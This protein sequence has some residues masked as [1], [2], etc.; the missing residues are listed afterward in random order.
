METPGLPKACCTSQAFMYQLFTDGC[1]R[2]HQQLIGSHIRSI[3][4]A[5]VPLHQAKDVAPMLTYLLINSCEG[6]S[7]LKLLV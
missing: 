7:V 3:T 6:L 5:N 1:R 2:P 4:A